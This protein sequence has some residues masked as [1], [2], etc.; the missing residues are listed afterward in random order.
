MGSPSRAFPSV[1]QRLPA[2]S[3]T[4]VSASAGGFRVPCSGTLR[5]AFDRIRAADSAGYHIERDLT[6]E[7]YFSLP[8]GEIR[9]SQIAQEVTD[10]GSIRLHTEW[11]NSGELQL[12]GAE[13]RLAVRLLDRVPS[14]D[15]GPALNLM[16][17]GVDASIPLERFGSRDAAPGHIRIAHEGVLL[18]HQSDGD[19]LVVDIVHPDEV[20]GRVQLAGSC[21]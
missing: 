20:A 10:V 21:W 2:G 8:V 7:R 19:R 11:L 17:H 15:A 16:I 13:G 5:G 18:N 12:P 6:P 3:V 9:E 4:A 14:T 1:V